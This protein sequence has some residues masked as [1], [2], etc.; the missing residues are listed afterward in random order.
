M[1][2]AKAE[3][4]LR[5]HRTQLEEELK[6]SMLLQ[7]MST[8]LIPEKDVE[9]LY[10]KLLKHHVGAD[11]FAICMLTNI[12]SGPSKR[13]GRS[14]FLHT[15]GSTS[16]KAACG[17]W[18]NIVSSSS[19]VEKFCKAGRILAQDVN[20]CDVIQGTAILEVYS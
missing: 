7:K 16:K 9:V 19:I 4:A 20:K 2:R 15:R 8:E 18:V 1:E 17:A 5:E 3:E 13:R 11:G 10:D 14:G 6:Y 12:L